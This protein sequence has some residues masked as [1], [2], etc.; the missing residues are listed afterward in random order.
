M[1]DGTVVMP[2]VRI[3]TLELLAEL[4]KRYPDLVKTITILVLK[5]RIKSVRDELSRIE[6]E[7]KRYREKYGKDLNEFEK[8]MSNSFEEHEDWIE[9]RFLME[10]K[11]SLEE[12]LRDLYKIL[13]RLTQQV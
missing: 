13:E 2:I 5:K 10:L 4:E 1:V 6:S 9:W 7:I 8:S 11:K 12:E 3:M